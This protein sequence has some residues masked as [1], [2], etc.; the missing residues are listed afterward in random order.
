[1]RKLISDA[2]KAINP[3]FSFFVKQNGEI[4]WLDPRKQPSDE[5]IQAKIKELK[6]QAKIDAKYDSCKNFIL[7]HY[8]QIKQQSDSADKEYF[9]TLLKANGVQNLEAD[10][11]AR[12]QNFFAGKTLDEVVEDVPDENKE[13]YI[14]LVKVGIRVTWVQQCKAELKASIAEDREPNFPKYPL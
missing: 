14:Q 11:V 1:M 10:I 7:Q 2:I 3:S 4:V 13:A 6:A 12:V 8:P 9:T 5:E